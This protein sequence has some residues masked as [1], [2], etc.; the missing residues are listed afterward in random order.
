MRRVLIAHQST[1]PH[2]RIPFYN[3]LEGLRPSTWR[4]DVVFDPYELEA[5]RFFQEKIDPQAFQFPILPVRTISTRIGR[6]RISYQTFW[7]RAAQYDLVIVEN[8]V[9]NL[10]YPLCHLHRIGGTRIAYW[11]HGK[12]RS[13]TAA[14]WPKRLIERSKLLQVRNSDGFFAY[15]AGV[16]AY[17]VDRGVPANKIHVVQ[18]TI[19]IEEQRRAFEE[20]QPKREAIRRRLGLDGKK[21]LLFVGRFIEQR[22]IEVLLE[23]FSILHSRDSAY[24]LLLVGSGAE[25]YLDDDLPGITQCG[26]IV[27][28]SALAR[29]YVASDL[30]VI[31]GWVGLGPLQ[32]LCYDL[33]VITIDAPQHAPEI[34]YL[35]AANSIILD[36]GA[37]AKEYAAAIDSLLA[38]P[39]RLTS[40]RSGIWR[41]IEHLTIDNMARN[42]VA[43]VNSILG[44]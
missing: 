7:L 28:L 32:A 5:K 38:D 22:R 10:A 25:A 19:D 34:E 8:A 6:K 24:H 30:Y 20:W 27:E 23:A 40:L 13:I 14:S 17:L 11:G 41:S 12:D 35:S 26:P 18:N 16:K 39:S 42:F 33:P 21:V 31:P 2:Y 4:F 15:T 9:N 37:T 3:A 1:I 43:G 36:R 29:R 44:L